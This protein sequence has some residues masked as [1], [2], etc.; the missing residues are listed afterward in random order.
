MKRTLSVIFVIACE[1]FVPGL[2]TL[3]A[4]SHEK[5]E[6]KVTESG[7][8]QNVKGGTTFQANLPYDKAY[9][10]VLNYLKRQGYTIDAASADT[11][12][13]ATAMDV[14]G[15]Y[16]QTGTRI[17]VVFIKDADSQT[18]LRVVVSEQKR[19]KLLQTEPWGDA[20]A[21]ESESAKLAENIKNA[22]RN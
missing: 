9:D 5:R 11:G 6:E 2:R 10:A 13:I 18:S 15:G 16:R 8:I 22:I 19:T 14:K 21:N 7:Q 20:R 17:I 4:Q 12:Q 1:M 3:E